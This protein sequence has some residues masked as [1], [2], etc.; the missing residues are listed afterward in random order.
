MQSN[1]IV[2]RLSDSDCRIPVDVNN[3]VQ[4]NYLYEGEIV[5]SQSFLSSSSYAISYASS[6]VYGFD[7][8]ADR[9]IEQGGE[10]EE[11]TCI[12]SFLNSV[13]IFPVDTVHIEMNNGDVKVV[14]VR[15][16]EECRYSPVK[17]S[18][19]NRWG[20]LQDLWFFRKSTK[21]LTTKKEEF[22]RAIMSND[23]YDTLVHPR[24]V[25]NVQSQE[26]ITINTGYV[27]ECYND[28]IQEL[29]QSE[30]VWMEQDTIAYPVVVDTSSLTYKTSVNDKLVDYTIDLSFAYDGIQNIR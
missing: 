20:A 24:K 27:D 4:V 22:K 17:V 6:Y 12:T 16:L 25:Y 15:T 3:V 28:P 2:Y 29:M 19:F 13:E 18:F 14:K 8:F 21:K 9:V 5:K 1:D 10:Y 23:S 11:N 7:S 26:T 30:Y